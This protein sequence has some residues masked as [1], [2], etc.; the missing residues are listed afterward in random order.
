MNACAIVPANPNPFLRC[1]SLLRPV[2]HRRSLNIRNIRWND[3]P[4][5]EGGL[6][7]RPCYKKKKKESCQAFALRNR[8]ISA[9]SPLHSSSESFQKPCRISC[10]DTHRLAS[11]S[12]FVTDPRLTSKRSFVCS[13]PQNPGIETRDKTHIQIRAKGSQPRNRRP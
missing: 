5:H 3:G 7:L 4:G 13:P 12:P 2:D 11:F 6:F 8:G 10:N 9:T 1:R